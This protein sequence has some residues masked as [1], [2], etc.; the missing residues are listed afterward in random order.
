[1]TAT[2][3]KVVIFPPVAMSG[4]ALIDVP[5]GYTKDNCAPDFGATHL[6][7]GPSLR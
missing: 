2:M 7:F 6:E 5:E 1:M 3:T 4:V